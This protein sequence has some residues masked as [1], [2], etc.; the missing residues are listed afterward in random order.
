MIT[1]KLFREELETLIDENKKFL[2]DLKY[3][4]VSTSV[5]LQIFIGQKIHQ[6]EG[7][8]LQLEEYEKDPTIAD[9]NHLYQ[10]F[11]EVRS[12]IYFACKKWRL[13]VEYKYQRLKS[14]LGKLYYISSL[15]A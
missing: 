14:R 15:G 11:G 12:D 9:L 13:Q 7:M 6:L 4:D 8:R 5:Y 3:Y 1:I 2:D 10:V